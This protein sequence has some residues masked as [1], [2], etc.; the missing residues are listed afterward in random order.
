MESLES[1]AM[2]AAGHYLR[3]RGYEIEHVDD[4]GMMIVAWDD[5]DLVIADISISSESGCGFPDGRDRRAMEGYA[6]SW[7]S[8]HEIGSDFRV[9]FDSVCMVVVGSDKAMIRHEI[10]ADS[11]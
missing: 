11:L 2:A 9:R 7:L 8:T 4:L 6:L 3:R 10:G 1:R 5:C